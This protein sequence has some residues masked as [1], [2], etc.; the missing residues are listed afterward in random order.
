MNHLK[1]VSG[2]HFSYLIMLYCFS[3]V[4]CSANA[5]DMALETADK[6]YKAENYNAAI[7]EYKRFIYYNPTNELV[8]DA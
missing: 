6:Y 2:F 3:M 1:F 7:T 4:I 5:N 8:S